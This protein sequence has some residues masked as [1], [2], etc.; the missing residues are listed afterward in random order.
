MNKNIFNAF[1]V[2][3][4]AMGLAS[5]SENSW[6]DHY[7]DGFEGGVDYEDAVEGTYT[8]TPSD[9]SSVASLM[10]Q[11]A[12]TDEEK[13]AAKAIGSNLYFDKSG[14][15]P[16]QVALPSFLET[17][18]FPYYLASNGSV[19]DVTYQEASAVPAEINALAGAK[20]YTVSAADYAKAWGSETAFIRAYAPDATAASN[21]PVALADAF[22]EQTIE[23]GTFAVVTYNNATQNPMFGLPDEVPASADLY[24]A[25]EFK[26]G[27]YLLFADGIVANIID[28][29]MA[30]G[31]Y[32]YFNAT[33]VSVSGNSISGFSLEN[34]VFVFTE[35]GTPGVY[36]MGDDL[37]HYYYGAERYNNFYISSVKGETDDYKW[38]VTKNEDGKWSIMNVL[39]QKY[40]E[41]SANYSTWGEYNDA[42]GVKPILY[43][44]NEEA[45][46]PTEIP[47]YT[48]VSVTENAVYCYNGGKWAVADGVVVLNPA[49]YTAMGFSNNSLSDAEIYIPLYL[50][51]K[52]PYAQSGAQ[53]FVV[54]NRNKADLF[55]F[56]G[57]NWVLNNNGL[58]TVTGRFQKK[59]NV[60]SFVKYVGKAIFDEFKEAEVIRDRSYL[61]VSGDICAVPVNKSNNYGYLQTASI[62][63]AN[64]QI[65]EK[66]DANA[67]TF[68]A[69]FTDEDAGTTTQAPAG[70]FLL[71]D[72]N[73]RYMYMSGTYSSANLSAK[74]TVDGGQIAAQYLWTASPNDDGTWA[75]K[76]VGNGRVMAYSSNYG[77]FGVYE[78][79]TENDHYPALYMLAE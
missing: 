20:S 34:N 60:W 45:S 62:S 79:L 30:D 68:A 1:I 17:S 61:L 57:S 56:D 9:Y 6:N 27:K 36:Y 7:L 5:C 46:T 54:Y 41:Y 23:E 37:G 51:N 76:N 47:L 29:T 52:L 21:I 24:E 49:D 19:V 53:E 3:S 55:V 58:E 2:G 26:A 43:V 65:I 8:L 15:Y 67:F 40:V 59:D 35:T 16:A 42:R 31:K 18:S 4:L 74:P 28:P 11:V 75:I 38:T 25:E 13:A 44:A 14:L 73:G 10:Q 12:V 32:S 70:Q 22:A 72:S 71:R 77:S 48:P 66:S 33:E 50:R 39:A 64:G 69:S 63:V 78:T